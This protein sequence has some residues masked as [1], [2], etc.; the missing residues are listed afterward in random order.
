MTKEERREH[1]HHKHERVRRAVLA[2][3]SSRQPGRN[4]LRLPTFGFSGIPGSPRITYPQGW[5]LRQPGPMGGALLI[6][7][8]AIVVAGIILAIAHIF[9]G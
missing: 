3:G 7:G 2:H 9:G 1:R 8:V 4:G 6:G 5:K